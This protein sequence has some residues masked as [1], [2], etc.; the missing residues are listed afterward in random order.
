MK[1]DWIGVARRLLE[2]S[3]IATRQNNPPAQMILIKWRQQHYFGSVQIIFPEF[4]PEIVL[5]SKTKQ[6]LPDELFEALRALEP[7][8]PLLAAF[9]M[10]DLGGNY[11]VL[12]RTGTNVVEMTPEQSEYAAA[13]IG[14]IQDQQGISNLAVLVDYPQRVFD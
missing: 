3:R 5:V 10:L 13:N 11:H 7:K 6:A 8:I 12:R 4:D 14:P 2:S 1:P 9:D